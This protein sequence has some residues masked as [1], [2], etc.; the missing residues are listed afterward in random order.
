MKAS[1]PQDSIQQLFGRRRGGYVLSMAPKRAVFKRP[2]AYKRPAAND[3]DRSSTSRRME[4]GPYVRASVCDFAQTLDAMLCCR[5]VFLLRRGRQKV[6]RLLPGLLEYDDFGLGVGR[7][8]GVSGTF[9]SQIGAPGDSGEP[10]LRYSWAARC[11][12]RTHWK[13]K[14]FS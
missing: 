12:V 1:S 2:A 5:E 13:C 7:N 4:E 3:V 6:D 10:S 9:C 14:G 8:F 11:C